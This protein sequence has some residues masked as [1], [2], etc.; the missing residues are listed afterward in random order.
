MKPKTVTPAGG[1]VHRVFPC[2]RVVAVVAVVSVVVVS[3][4]VSV[5]VI[6]GSSHRHKIMFKNTQNKIVK[7]VVGGPIIFDFL[8]GNLNF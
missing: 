3:T 2:L 5:V 8:N 4:V 7:I 1:N 6:V